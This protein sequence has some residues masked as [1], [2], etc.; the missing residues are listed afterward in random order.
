M[1]VNTIRACVAEETTVT[2]GS[3]VKLR[4]LEP[5]RIGDIPVP[6]NT[7]LY[8]TARIEGQRLNLVITSIESSGN[9]VPVELTAYDTD[10]QKGLF[11]PNSTERTAAKEALA[12]I[13]QSFGTSVSFARGA[14]QQ[15]A[16][17]VTR[18]VMSGG[19][20]YLA[21]KMREVKITLKSGYQ[22]LLISKEK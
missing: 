6:A 17:D 20:Q 21:T 1:S 3:R 7:S 10:G 14:G 2:T 12:G 15:V 13:G 11:I 9:V 16:M 4:L 8:G 19:S 18:G 22:I 5:L